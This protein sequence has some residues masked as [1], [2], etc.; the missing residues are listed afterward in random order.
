MK[1]ILYLVWSDLIFIFVVAIFDG[2]QYA[3]SGL[4]LG[5]HPVLAVLLALLV[6]TLAIYAA[7]NV[8]VAMQRVLLV[9]VIIFSMMAYIPRVTLLIEKSVTVELPNLKEMTKPDDKL[10]VASKNDEYL[11]SIKAE[12]ANIQI[13][14]DLEINRVKN[15]NATKTANALTEALALAV[16]IVIFGTLL[17]YCLYLGSKRLAEKLKFMQ[18]MELKKQVANVDMRQMFTQSCMDIENSMAALADEFN[19]RLE[20]VYSKLDNK[21]LSLTSVSNEIAKQREKKAKEVLRTL[22]AFLNTATPDSIINYS[23]WAE[24][25]KI[26]RSIVTAIVKRQAEVNPEIRKFLP[27]VRKN[28]Y[29]VAVNRDSTGDNSLAAE[30]NS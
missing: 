21:A 15:I 7:F 1:K 20:E 4:V 13:L 18:R 5:F 11:Q 29:P 23:E 19:K 27:T 14:N 3:A 28:L 24:K 26:D 30:S 6:V 17:P 22:D 10:R 9:A 25:L 12:N 8:T 2:N 16:V